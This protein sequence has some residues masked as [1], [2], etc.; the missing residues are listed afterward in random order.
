VVFAGMVILNVAGIGVGFGS[1]VLVKALD[2]AAKTHPFAVETVGA[3]LIGTFLYQISAVDPALKVHPNW[4][5]V[6]AWLYVFTLNVIALDP[7]L[8]V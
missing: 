8:L 3:P 7:L 2:V 1:A 4:V 5:M 6:T